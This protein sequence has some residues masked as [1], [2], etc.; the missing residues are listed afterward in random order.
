MVKKFIPPATSNYMRN[1]AS[2]SQLSCG[3]D[4]F[5]P[6]TADLVKQDNINS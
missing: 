1:A 3:T 5:Q 6:R 2:N 4:Y